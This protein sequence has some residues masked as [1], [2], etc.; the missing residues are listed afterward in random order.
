MTKTTVLYNDTCPIC[1]R[2]IK[3]Y[4][5]LTQSGDLPIDFAPLSTKADNWGFD[6]DTAARQ[7]HVRQG[8]TVLGGAD[9]FI[10]LWGEIPRYQWLAVLCKLPGINTLF[11]FLYNRVAAPALFALHKRRQRKA[12]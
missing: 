9:A 2:E 5:R 1:A 10:A 4:Y 8:D 3:H 7:L 12:G 11:R 6:S